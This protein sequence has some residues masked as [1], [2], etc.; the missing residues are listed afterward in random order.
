MGFLHEKVRGIALLLLV[1]ISFIQLSTEEER[2]VANVDDFGNSYEVGDAVSVTMLL[3]PRHHLFERYPFF[4]NLECEGD[5]PRMGE[6]FSVPF[7]RPIDHI[8]LC[9]MLLKKGESGKQNRLMD[10][11]DDSYIIDFEVDDLLAH[12]HLGAT[13]TENINDVVTGFMK[14]VRSNNGGGLESVYK[15]FTHYHLHIEY[16]DDKII[17][18]K[19]YTDIREQN[20][21][22]LT[23]ASNPDDSS[24]EF[25]YSVSWHGT[26]VDYQGRLAARRKDSLAGVIELR[27]NGI[28]HSVLLFVTLVLLI[29]VFL[30][31]SIADDILLLKSLSSTDLEDST[32]RKPAVRWQGLHTSAFCPPVQFSLLIACTGAGAGLFGTLVL[33][34]VQF[35]FLHH[36]IPRGTLLQ[37]FLLSFLTMTFIAGIVT[38]VVYK[39]VDNEGRGIQ[40]AIVTSSKNSWMI[41]TLQLFLTYVGPTFLTFCFVN[42]MGWLAQTTIALPWGKVVFIVLGF[43]IALPITFIGAVTGRGCI[44]SGPSS[45]S[46]SSR[47]ENKSNLMTTPSEESSIQTMTMHGLFWLSGFLAFSSIMVE[48]QY[49]FHSIWAHEQYE[50]YVPPP[51]HKL[52]KKSRNDFSKSEPGLETEQKRRSSDDYLPPPKPQHKKKNSSRSWMNRMFASTPKDKTAVKKGIH[53]KKSSKSSDFNS[54]FERKLG[55]KK[56]SSAKVRDPRLQGLNDSSSSFK[57]KKREL[58]PPPPTP[59]VLI[60]RRLSLR[61]SGRVRRKSS[62]RLGRVLSKR[63]LESRRQE[64]DTFSEKQEHKPTVLASGQEEEIMTSRSDKQQP[65]SINV[66]PAKPKPPPPPKT[67]LFHAKVPQQQSMEDHAE[68]TGTTKDENPATKGETV[69]EKPKTK[70]KKKFGKFGSLMSKSLKSGA[71]EKAVTKMESDMEKQEEKEKE[72]TSTVPEPPKTKPKK[73]FGKFGSLMSKSLKSGALEKAVTKMENDMANQ[74][75]EEKEKTSAIPEPPKTKPKKKLGKFGSLMS[76]SLKSGALEKAVTKMENDMA[77]QEKE[78]KEKTSAIPKPEPPKTKPKKKFGKFG[79]LMSKSLKSG[80]LEKAVT[81]MENDMAN[82]ETEN[83]LQKDDVPENSVTDEHGRTRSATTIIHNV[84]EDTKEAKK[85]QKDFEEQERIETAKEIVRRK[86]RP[87]VQEMEARR[88]LDRIRENQSNVINNK[89]NTVYDVQR[90]MS[91]IRKTNAVSPVPETFTLDFTKVKRKQS[92]GV[93]ASDTAGLATIMDFST[94]VESNLLST[95]TLLSF[96][97]DN[98]IEHVAT[99]SGDRPSIENQTRDVGAPSESTLNDRPSIETDDEE[100]PMSRPRV[101]SDFNGRSS[102]SPSTDAPEDESTLPKLYNHATRR[103]PSFEN[104]TTVGV[105]TDPID[106]NA[107]PSLQKR[108]QSLLTEK[109]RLSDK[110][111]ER[112]NM[113]NKKT[114]SEIV[115]SAVLEQKVSELEGLV[116]ASQRRIKKITKE[117]EDAE[118]QWAQERAHMLQEN[119]LLKDKM[120][121]LNIKHAIAAS[122]GNTDSLSRSSRLTRYNMS[123][124]GNGDE[125]SSDRAS[126]EQEKKIRELQNK[127][128]FFKAEMEKLA[129]E[130]ERARIS[131]LAVEKQHQAELNSYSERLTKL[132]ELEVALQS[133]WEKVETR[134]RAKYDQILER[135]RDAAREREKKLVAAATRQL[136]T[137]SI[138]AEEKYASL[139]EDVC[140]NVAAVHDKMRKRETIIWREAEFR[141]SAVIR[142]FNEKREH[143]M[144]EQKKSAQEQFKDVEKMYEDMYRAAVRATEARNKHRERVIAKSTLPKTEESLDAIHLAVSA[145][146][147]DQKKLGL[148]DHQRLVAE[149]VRL[150]ENV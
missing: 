86:R 76:K 75:K 59:R 44:S 81:K 116:Q 68:K 67:N 24:V 72:K 113:A 61:K 142:L 11:I 129:Q 127:V 79:S 106:T 148:N 20:V 18:F 28:W 136:Q 3:G 4:H 34:L 121:Q 66:T 104:L 138:A 97:E 90:R 49:I 110:M 130:N 56:Q 7:R 71:L 45:S 135:E 80:A 140:E 15:L 70:P 111:K 147:E 9:T 94:P 105:Q 29:S 85:I 134:V 146:A 14:G 58:P 63:A 89:R 137:L 2:I 88:R 128:Q 69:P 31:G 101:Y 144:I 115:K 53:K 65:S 47:M 37:S 139:G 150:K 51:A 84:D 119:H 42:T 77:N 25:M 6:W 108:I 12:A 48:L 26:N 19:V 39:I 13:P 23:D 103:R 64:G 123:D 21:Y 124:L 82:K 1:L 32:K 50:M 120:K 99:G 16:N 22:N 91:H 93:F 8:P 141:S 122:Q 114:Q 41:N 100:R 62:I 126:E 60:Q 109:K 33:C 35:S 10:M 57:E 5:A 96:P 145:A 54:V 46:S 131:K 117:R 73:K 17:H 95:P 43:L 87:S 107:N 74:E 78:E 98:A 55:K 118:E 52:K 40:H 36:P 92:V 102:V 132:H 133:A 143:D 83:E 125:D 112:V 27:W 38:G 30:W 149:N